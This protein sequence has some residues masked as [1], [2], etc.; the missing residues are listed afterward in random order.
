[1]RFLRLKLADS[2]YKVLNAEEEDLLNNEPDDRTFILRTREPTY[3]LQLLK[4]QK[5]YYKDGTG[6]FDDGDND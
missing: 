4:K 5:K 3:Y 2:D 6:D 1:M